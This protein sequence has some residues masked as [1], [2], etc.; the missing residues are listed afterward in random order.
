M[1]GRPGQSN[2]EAVGGAIDQLHRRTETW[3]VMDVTINQGRNG[4]D[5]NKEIYE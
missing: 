2:A 4:L 3:F 1:A 5:A